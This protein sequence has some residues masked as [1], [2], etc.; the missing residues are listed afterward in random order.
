MPQ[1]LK[2]LAA[3]SEDPSSI[4]STHK[5]SITP[6]PGDLTHAGKTPM[7]TKQKKKLLKKAKPPLSFDVGYNPKA[8]PRP[9]VLGW[10]F[11]PQII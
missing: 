4:P 9:R 10:F 5:L 2:A 7:H 11:P 1:Q 3:L 8:C 6:V